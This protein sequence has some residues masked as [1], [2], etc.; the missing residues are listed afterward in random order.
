MGA[1]RGANDAISDY[2]REEN[3]FEI[4]SDVVFSEKVNRRDDTMTYGIG[5]V[6]EHSH[7]ETSAKAKSGVKPKSRRKAAL[8]GRQAKLLPPRTSC[9]KPVLPSQM[10]LNTKPRLLRLSSTSGNNSSGG[11]IHAKD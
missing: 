11:G 4:A 6:D 9:F 3:P 8:G 1:E 7:N 10:Q 2:G 5:S